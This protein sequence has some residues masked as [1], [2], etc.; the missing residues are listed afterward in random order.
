MRKPM[1]NLAAMFGAAAILAL[2]AVAMTTGGDPAPSAQEKEGKVVAQ[3]M[4]EE[5]AIVKA[6][7]MKKRTVTLQMSD[8]RERTLVV[9]KAVKKLGEVKVGDTVKASY[10]E[11]VSVKINK[12]KVA[13]GAKVETA[14]KRDEKSV[15]PAGTAS[16]KATTTATID[17]IFDDGRKVTLRTP[18]GDTTDVEVR[19][20]ENLAKIKKGE[21][22]EGDQIQITY[23]RALAISVEKCEIMQAE[24]LIGI[25]EARAT[26]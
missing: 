17:R 24:A 6:I 18:D 3:T 11:A 14:I 9:D 20:P 26:T 2:P 1:K 19:D 23:Y 8:G 22:K 15:K 12:V 21:V 7:D 16:L 5:H 4:V 10:R 13:P 25:R